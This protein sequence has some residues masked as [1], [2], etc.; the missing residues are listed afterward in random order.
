MSYLGRTLFIEL[1]DLGIVR[2]SLNYIWLVTCSVN[3]LAT[4]RPKTDKTLP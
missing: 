2:H 4:I 1:T 3:R